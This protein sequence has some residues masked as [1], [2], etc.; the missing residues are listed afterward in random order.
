MGVPRDQLTFVII[1]LSSFLFVIEVE[2]SDGRHA[3]PISQAD[4]LLS[5]KNSSIENYG[6][7]TCTMDWGQSI[8]GVCSWKGVVCSSSGD[9][10]ALELDGCGILGRLHF[11]DLMP[12]QHLRNIS[13]S[14]NRFYES[15]STS[16]ISSFPCSFQFVDLSL[17]LFQEVESVF[18]HPCKSL[19]TLNLSHNNINTFPKL[20]IGNTLKSLYLSTNIMDGYLPIFEIQELSELEHLDLSRNQFSGFLDPTVLPGMTK[21]L[22][23]DLSYNDF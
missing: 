17:N 7:L 12:L 21:F 15:I 11:G 2:R 14:N 22:S 8:S 20:K 4:A 1:L 19:S 13:F 5:F 9:V 6:S 10:V 23:L 3:T 18:L 16:S